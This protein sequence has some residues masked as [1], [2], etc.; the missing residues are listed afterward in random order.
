MLVFKLMKKMVLISKLTTT[1][2]KKKTRNIL[3]IIIGSLAVL[4]FYGK[5]NF[6]NDKQSLLVLKTRSGNGD[7]N[8]ALQQMEN[9]EGFSNPLINQSYQK[10][11]TKMQTR[12]ITKDENIENTSGNKIVNDISN[13]YRDYWRTEL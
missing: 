2:M 10:W 11:K 6:E 12:F 8:Y 3:F 1:K 13:I 5:H 4:F 7:V 9:I